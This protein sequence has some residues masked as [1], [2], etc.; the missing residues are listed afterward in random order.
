MADLTRWDREYAAQQQVEASDSVSEEG[1]EIVPP[2]HSR[3]V[4][5]MPVSFAVEC[6]RKSS[7][8]KLTKY[9]RACRECGTRMCKDCA[10]KMR[11]MRG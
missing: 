6:E 10:E 3:S 5:K 11:G 7:Q 2:R 8:S 9:N 1:W 4:R